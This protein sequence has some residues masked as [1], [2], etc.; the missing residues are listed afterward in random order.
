M[1]WLSGLTGQ[2]YR[3]LTKAEWEYAARAGT[4]GSYHWGNNAA[5]SRANFEVSSFGSGGTTPV[6][7]YSENAW[8]LHDVHGNAWE[9]VEDCW[10]NSYEVSGVR[11]PANGTA[12][13]EDCTPDSQKV[14]RGGSWNTLFGNARSASR[15]FSSNDDEFNTIGFRVARTIP[16]P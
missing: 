16:M 11:A 1:E 9:W 13:T 8:G 12:W 2:S 15:E 5:R 3:L 6:G 10:H 7:A 4:T 14:R